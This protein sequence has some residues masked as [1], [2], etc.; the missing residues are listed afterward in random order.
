ME[1]REFRK[2]LLSGKSVYGTL[3]TSPSPRSFDLTC[4]L[5]LDFVFLCNEHIF[6]NPEILGWMCRAFRAKGINPVIR[7]LEPS[8]FLATQ[9]LD[10][11]AGAIVVPY[12]ENI[13]DVLDL[14]GAVKFRPLKGKKLK[15]ILN[16]E[17][18]LSEEMADYIRKHNWNNTLILNIESPEGIRNMDNFLSIGSTDGPGV[19]GILLG[20]HDLSVSSEIPERYNSEEFIKLSCDVIKKARRAGVGAGGH[21]GFRGSLSLQTE[22]AKAGA[23]IILHSSD[24]FLFGDKLS[25]EMN[26]LRNIKN[27]NSI[28]QGS[29]ENV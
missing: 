18:K 16:G 13:E 21:T 8:P 23:N 5:G 29:S 14:V 7:I 9:A 11:G 17:E 10:S 27:E 28:S 6:Y 22:W 1:G 4:S 3:I 2:A 12:I 25:E 15:R 20:P 19:D 24:M 26:Y